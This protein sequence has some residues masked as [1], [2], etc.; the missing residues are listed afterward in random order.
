MDKRILLS[1]TGAS[2]SIF[3]ERLAEY[4]CQAEDVARVYIVASKAAVQVVQHE[5]KPHS[6]RFSLRE[7][8]KDKKSSHDASEKMR[9]FDCD[10][11]FS[12]LASGSAA[13]THT[14]I[15]P[16][17]MG[18]MARIAGG[19][20]SNLIERS[21]DVALK[22]NRPLIICPRETPLNQI[23]IKNMLTLSQAG[24]QIAP[25]MP[26]FYQKPETLD[27]MVDFMVGRVL[28]LLE[29]KHELYKPWNARLR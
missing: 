21:A 16:C 3:A 28:E 2:G 13:S 8:L 17:S 7:V 20:S 4:L 22:Q 19:I 5:L 1:I 10:D 23:H 12:P 15:L 18:T 27:D 6:D 25:L 29:V 9:V 26:A 24:A 11:L 14:V